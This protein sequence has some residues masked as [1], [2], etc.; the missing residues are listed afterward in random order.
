VPTT[1]NR[2]NGDVGRPC[3]LAQI[4]RLSA[5]PNN[6]PSGSDVKGV[7]GRW[8]MATGAVGYLG[9]M[10]GGGYTPRKIQANE[11]MPNSSSSLAS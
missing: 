7:M 9:G 11:L 10:A 3:F 4:D 8:T 6:P 5:T 1:A 2:H